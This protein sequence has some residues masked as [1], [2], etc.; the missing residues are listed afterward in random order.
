[1][2]TLVLAL[3]L[4]ASAPAAALRLPE[5]F[6]TDMAIDPKYAQE[7]IE[8]VVGFFRSEENSKVW[9]AAQKITEHLEQV[10]SI[11]KAHAGGASSHRKLQYSAL[12]S[13]CTSSVSSLEMLPDSVC[14]STAGSL[15]SAYTSISSNCGLNLGA[16]SSATT[17]AGLSAA[18]NSVCASIG[19]CG[20]GG[21]T[22]PRR[23]A[24]PPRQG[25]SRRRPSCRS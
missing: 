7:T 22:G 17:C 20:S 16:M 25:C 15:A 19:S 23:P 14:A 4:G 21:S 2:R 1:M 3:L 5:S 8:K 11:A 13:A 24:A 6:P 18:M 9:A 12:Q 10:E